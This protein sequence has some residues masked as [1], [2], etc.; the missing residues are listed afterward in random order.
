MLEVLVDNA[1][2]PIIAEGLRKSGFDAVHVR[3][4][5]LQRA[6]DEEIFSRAG[7]EDRVI[8]SADT[9]FGTL[10]ALRKIKKPSI[11][12]FRG[13]SERRPKQQLSLLLEHLAEISELLEEGGIVIFEQTRIRLRSLPIAGD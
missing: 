12:I 4:Y 8:V 13:G 1:L 5:N 9:D 6:T 11:I 3:D 7:D 10:L 2:S